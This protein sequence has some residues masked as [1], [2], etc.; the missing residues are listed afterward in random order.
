MA[1]KRF[2]RD[3]EILATSEIPDTFM[4][5]DEHDPKHVTILIS[6]ITFDIYANTAY[7]FLPPKATYIN[8]RDEV[9]I[10]KSFTGWSPGSTLN[11]VVYSILLDDLPTIIENVIDAIETK[12]GIIKPEITKPEIT[13]TF[14]RENMNS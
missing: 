9:V 7:P 6:G 8:S 5:Q 2:A 10:M 11:D 12:T 3:L 1:E 4:I 14:V 13:K